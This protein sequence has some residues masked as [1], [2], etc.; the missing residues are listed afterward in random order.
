MKTLVSELDGARLE[1]VLPAPPPAR[2]YLFRRPDGAEVVVGW[3]SAADRPVRAVLP[4]PAVG[5]DRAGTAQ[6]LP[7]ARERSGAGPRSPRYFRAVKTYFWNTSA[8]GT[9][10]IGVGRTL[11]GTIV[12]S[13]SVTSALTWLL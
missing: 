7:V 10:S 8:T 4:R 9:I 3:S 11:S 12:L 1:E 2:L 5:R 6:E 13:A